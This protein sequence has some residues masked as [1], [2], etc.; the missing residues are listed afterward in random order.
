[1]AMLNNQ[2]IYALLLEPTNQYPS[3]YLV[4]LA[5]EFRNLHELLPRCLLHQGNVR[6]WRFKMRP[7]DT[8]NISKNIPKS[9]FFLAV[10]IWSIFWAS[11]LRRWQPQVKHGKMKNCPK[12]TDVMSNL[13]TIWQV[14]WSTRYAQVISLD[15]HGLVGHIHWAHIIFMHLLNE[16]IRKIVDCTW[17]CHQAPGFPG[18]PS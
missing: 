5:C 17:L 18:F 14:W 12:S 1:M 6:V 3:W 11:L 2:M 9:Q 15:S 8:P 10:W 7:W 13:L 16:T 4:S